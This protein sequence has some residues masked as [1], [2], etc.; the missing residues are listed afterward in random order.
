MSIDIRL[1]YTVDAA[2]K[3]LAVETPA[4]IKT[5]ATIALEAP[6]GDPDAEGAWRE[7]LGDAIEAAAAAS[8]TS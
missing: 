7:L 6:R 3:T 4:G 8:E 5:L 2:R 1:R